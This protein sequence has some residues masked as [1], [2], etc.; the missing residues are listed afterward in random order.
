MEWMVLIL[1]FILWSLLEQVLGRSRGR[2]GPEPPGDGVEGEESGPLRRIERA[3]TARTVEEWIGEELG[4]N[5]ERRP[6]VRTP[7]ERR[8]RPGSGQPSERRWRR[9]VRLP[10]SGERTP[11]DRREREAVSLE[12]EPQIVSLEEIGAGERGA[13][14]SLERPRT[15]ADHERFHERYRVPKPVATH[16]E[17]H[18]RYVPSAMGAPRVAR[19]RGARLPELSHASDLQKMIVWSEILSRP[20]GLAPM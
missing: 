7:R 11:R 1:I 13:P 12:E 17:F 4:I 2:S 19:R 14:K 6:R 20:R 10:R 9:E 8:P 3:E 18:R 5:L 15:P 16:E